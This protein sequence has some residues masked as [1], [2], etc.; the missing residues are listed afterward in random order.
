M[1]KEEILQL[2]KEIGSCENME[3]VRA[4]LVNLEKVLNEDYTTHE[5]TI[6][7]VAELEERNN[8]L[9]K[10][11][12]DLYLQVGSG[13]NPEDK[14]KNNEDPTEDEELTYDNL[15]DEEGGLK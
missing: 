9:T 6:T 11:N 15:F 3:D 2:A 13:K 7:K 12:M 14:T 4:K 10:A 8:K 5:T 1:K